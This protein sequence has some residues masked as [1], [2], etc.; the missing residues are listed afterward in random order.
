VNEDDESI[1]EVDLEEVEEEIARKLLAIAV[2]YSKKS[3][4][5]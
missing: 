2:F 5:P 3:Y 4:N 1:L